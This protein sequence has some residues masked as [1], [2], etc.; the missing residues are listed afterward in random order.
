M[1]VKSGEEPKLR[2]TLLDAAI[3]ITL[4][5]I[6]ACVGQVLEPGAGGDGPPVRPPGTVGPVTAD[7]ASESGARRLTTHELDNT[8]RDL[9]GDD[10]RQATSMLLAD[11]FQPFDNDYTVQMASEALIT[12]LE[13]WATDVSGYAISDAA[14]R[15]TIVP[16]APTG[17]GD[18]ACFRAFIEDFAPK[19]FR[20]PITEE[21]I[22]RYMTLQAFS[23]EDIPEVDNDFYTGIELVI[24]AILQ[25]PEFL[26]RIE[27]GTPTER[28]GVFAL[29]GYEIATRMSYFLWAST[30][31]ATLLGEAASGALLTE[32]GRRAAATRMLADPRA[33]D[34]MR[35]FHTMWLGYRIIPHDVDLVANFSM[36][37]GALIDRIVF[38]EPQ[39]YMNL[40]TFEESYLNDALATHY[41]L[42]APSGGEGWVPYGDSGRAGIL[43]HGALLSAFAKFADTSPTQRGIFI[44]TRLMCQTI[45]PPPPTVDVDDEPAGSSPDDCK[46]DRYAAHRD[47]PG[48]AGCHN[49]MDPIGFGLENYDMAGVF[50]EH[51]EGRPE[52]TIAGDGNLPDGTTFNGPA[53]LADLLIADGYIESCAMEQLYSFA[54]G[55]SAKGVESE[56]V[57]EL[58][59][60]FSENGHDLGAL[61]TDFT[62][63]ERFA[64]RR[65]EAL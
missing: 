33:R 43:S 32:E 48:C 64:H 3:I 53:E 31:D 36:E 19:A 1:A 7:F 20:R 11:Q 51:D 27:V 23:T 46:F 24:R 18:T 4:A 59:G 26:Y 25:D 34:Q 28:E 42:P 8:I 5:G 22:T 56:A 39:D 50:R 57:D 40:F 16:C 2:R 21:E 37:T 61:I 47:S 17:P 55:R 10:R 12:S 29:D 30:P 6:G 62:A 49:E 60:M 52:C 41:G 15:D 45:P 54:I 65:E 9:L 38:E 44:R 58:V 13:I 14:L 35:R 63:S